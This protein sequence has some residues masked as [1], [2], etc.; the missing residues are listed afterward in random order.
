MC[1][2]VRTEIVIWGA[3]TEQ[4]KC[5]KRSIVWLID[6]VVP[7]FNFL[8][9]NG[10]A[11]SSTATQ[12]KNITANPCSSDENCGNTSPILV[13]HQNHHNSLL[14]HPCNQ[15]Q[16]QNWKVMEFQNALSF[17]NSAQTWSRTWVS[18]TLTIHKEKTIVMWLVSSHLGHRSPTAKKIFE[19]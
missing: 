19:S 12:V 2:V 18:Y 6:I 17:P 13:V 10:V 15:I 4:L 9:T 1:Q 16:C 8:G 3:S 14:S 11:I 5:I 7:F